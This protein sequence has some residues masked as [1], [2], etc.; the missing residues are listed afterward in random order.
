MTEYTSRTNGALKVLAINSSGR[1]KDSVSRML[2]K[3]LVAA[4]QDRYDDVVVRHRELST[5]TSLVNETW[6]NAN[7]TAAAD[8]TPEQHDRLGE[9]DELVAE[10][11]EA[12]VI[13]LG[14]PMYNF[15]IPAALKAWVDMIARAGVTFRYTENGP[16]GLL[17]DK[18]AYLVVTTGGAPVDSAVDFATPYLRHL[19]GFIGIKDV[20]VVP[21]DRLNSNRDES[22]DAAR[23]RIAELIHS[24]VRGIVTSGAAA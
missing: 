8:R 16:Q 14:V 4:L 15:G 2:G 6:I 5:G 17:Q 1:N 13:V 20:E 7:F 10:L 23:S 11:Q 21:A 22:I 12:D 19:L 18:K 3:E 24:P 9:S